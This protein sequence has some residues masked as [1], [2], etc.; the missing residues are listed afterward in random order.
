MNTGFIGL[1]TM[2]GGMA[3]N[4]LKAGH[5]LTVLDLRRE[6][7]RPFLEGGA[8]WA[9]TPKELAAA[10]DIVFTSLPSPSEVESVALG[11]GGIIEGI[12]TG[13][14]YIDLSTS[15]PTLA[16]RIYH[17]FKEKG[18]RVLDAPV[19]G[20]PI[21][22]R[23]GKL[24]LMV[25]GDEEV[26]QRCKPV[27]DVLGDKVSYT[28]GIGSG[29]I[30]KLMHNCILYGL[31]TILAE[32]FSLGVKAGVEPR[33]LWQA[34]RDGVVGRGILI[35]QVLPDTYFRGR[36]DPPNFALRL[37]FKDVGLATSLA[38]EFDVPMAMANLTFQ[39]LM[40]AMNRGWGDRDSRVAMLL[41]EERAGGVQV[42][43]SE[44]ESR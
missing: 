30:C 41:Q 31:Q 26:F 35:H 42:R 18:A 37:A 36:F 34:I 1:G 5:R 12:P 40:S 44:V 23:S 20:G 43:I 38:R 9:E 15:S 6:T 2:G 10:S 28:G 4:I 21:A 39:E 19:S 25:G 27:L 24:A 22:A 8:V 3:A 13:G 16:R 29:S 32:C 7:A 14:V 33:A 17:V 11:K